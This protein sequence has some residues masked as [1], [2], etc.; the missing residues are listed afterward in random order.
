[1]TK[2]VRISILMALSKFISLK[3][4]S[5][6]NSKFSTTVRQSLVKRAQSNLMVA[7]TSTFIYQKINQR[8][9]IHHSP[10]KIAVQASQKKLVLL[11]ICNF[12]F[13]I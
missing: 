5:Y 9:K 1:M 10:L 8:D 3:T 4:K 6:Q 12:Y 13:R 7:R 2:R 11:M